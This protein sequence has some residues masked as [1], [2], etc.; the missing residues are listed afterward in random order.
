M[1]TSI[2]FLALTSLMAV[3]ADEVSVP[4][5]FVNRMKIDYGGDNLRQAFINAGVPLA[6]A[7]KV[8]FDPNQ[9]KLS[10]STGETAVNLI[11][12][13]VTERSMGRPGVRDASHV[14]TAL[15]G[16]IY[17]FGGVTLDGV[18]LPNRLKFSPDSSASELDAPDWREA[19]QYR[20]G[21]TN[22]GVMELRSLEGNLVLTGR[23]SAIGELLVASPV[24]TTEL[25][26]RAES[27]DTA[28]R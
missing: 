26:L 21:V 19:K 25:A 9:S 14:R 24:R 27:K 12:A 4:P 22:S 28:Q 23:L 17:R 15:S 2:L 8:E 13:L 7:D 11:S 16:K 1:K 20:W 18:E 6:G 5:D 3:H 10:F